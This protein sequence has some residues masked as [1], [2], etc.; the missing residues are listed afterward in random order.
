MSMTA[1]SSSAETICRAL[2]FPT[3]GVVGI[4]D[5][6][7]AVCGETGVQ[8]GWDAER[9]EVR[10]PG[11]ASGELLEV[12]LRKSVFRAILARVAVLCNQQ[13]PNSVGPY[14]GHGEL[15]VGATPARV[16]KVAFA[17]T[18]GEQKLEL[19]PVQ[20]ALPRKTVDAK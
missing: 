11:A 4:V 12:P 16:F 13:S 3:R 18:P 6:L 10:I 5:D 9:C 1:H 20:S 2:Q 17:N 14:G 15:S 8:L 7:L 19:T